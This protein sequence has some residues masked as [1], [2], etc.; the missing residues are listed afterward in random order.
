MLWP[1]Y[2]ITGRKEEMGHPTPEAAGGP[3]SRASY[4]P[5]EMGRGA[6]RDRD[7]WELAYQHSRIEQ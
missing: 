2:N 4:I 6:N 5:R 1:G 3:T 7:E